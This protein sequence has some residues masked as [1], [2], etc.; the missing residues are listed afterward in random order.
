MVLRAGRAG[1]EGG[2]GGVGGEWDDKAGWNE[3]M[4]I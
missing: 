2:R 1:D 3:G 4:H